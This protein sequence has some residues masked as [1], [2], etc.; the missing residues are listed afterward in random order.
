MLSIELQWV[1]VSVSEA[2]SPSLDRCSRRGEHR[3]RVSWL[4]RAGYGVG[5]GADELGFRG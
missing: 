4:A 2:S 3:L 5:E 1:L